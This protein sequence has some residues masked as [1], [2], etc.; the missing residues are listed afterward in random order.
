[1]LDPFLGTGTT[2]LA[3][4]QCGRDSVG[5]EIDPDYFEFT[6]RRLKSKTTGLFSHTELFFHP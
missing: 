4:A 5:S 6:Q 2:S 1:V 3:A